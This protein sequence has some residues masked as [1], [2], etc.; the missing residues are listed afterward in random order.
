M[1]RLPFLLLGAVVLGLLLWR[2][3]PAEILHTFA[4][5]G[6]QSLPILV[7]YV[8]Y[9]AMRAAALRFSILRWRQMPFRD[10]LWVRLSGDAM[11][12]L[13]FSGPF[14]GEPTKAWL[15]ARR[16][17][18]LTEGFAATLAEYQANLILCAAMSVPA[19]PYLLRPAELPPSAAGAA[20]GVAYVSAAFLLMARVAI[21]LRQ[22]AEPRLP[23]DFAHPGAKLVAARRGVRPRSG[24]TN[25]IARRENLGPLAK[26]PVRVRGF[27]LPLVKAGRR[28]TGTDVVPQQDSGHRI[29]GAHSQHVERQRHR[30]G[31]GRRRR[32]HQPAVP[33]GEQA[34]PEHGGAEQRTNTCAH[35]RR[36]L[37]GRGSDDS[38]RPEGR[39]QQPCA[40]RQHRA[41]GA[42]IQLHA[43]ER[44]IQN[45][46][47]EHGV[48]QAEGHLQYQAH[49]TPRRRWQPGCRTR[50]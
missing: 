16:G 35:G 8:V 17:L 29:P 37:I 28:P 44:W 2:L 25:L 45:R 12:S 6:W 4:R 33:G 10:A 32:R 39:H 48:D 50:S 30:T 43:R 22:L 47:V 26:D 38:Q 13:T 9:Q 1:I 18:T 34:Q 11:Q 40:R 20:R 49:G 7:C 23:V 5:L 31:V 3:G 24:E 36:T 14:R 46:E 21:V 42:G 27:P 19:L 15:L 41:P